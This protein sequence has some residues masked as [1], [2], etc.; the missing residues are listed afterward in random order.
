MCLYIVQNEK[1]AP[2]IIDGAAFSFYPRYLINHNVSA[3]QGYIGLQHLLSG[4]SRLQ[5]LSA[6]YENLHRTGLFH[7]LGF[8]I[9]Q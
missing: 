5:R 2:S 8:L 3:R 6:A 7:A 1:A 9:Q 4:Q